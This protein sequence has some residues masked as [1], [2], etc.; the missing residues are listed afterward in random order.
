MLNTFPWKI[1]RKSSCYLGHYKGPE[2]SLPSNI[3]AS[4]VM[5]YTSAPLQGYKAQHDISGDMTNVIIAVS[6]LELEKSLPL[7]RG[8]P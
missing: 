3:S 2:R 7:W 8:L 1:T 5:T 6:A 4:F